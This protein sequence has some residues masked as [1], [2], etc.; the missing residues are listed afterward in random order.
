MRY[1]E[2]L[3]HSSNNS[4]FFFSF[5]N[6]ISE[7]KFI[8]L[9]IAYL[10]KAITTLWLHIRELRFTKDYNTILTYSF[11]KPLQNTVNPHF[12]SLHLFAYYRSPF[13]LSTE[14][15]IYAANP[16]PHNHSKVDS[17]MIPAKIL[18]ILYCYCHISTPIGLTCNNAFLNHDFRIELF[19]V[20]L[21]RK[22]V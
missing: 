3:F 1:P 17:I 22:Q 13:I 6:L 2:S 21:F 8:F 9:V 12:S 7:R 14:Y 4:L 15:A 20:L 10:E 16:F 11:D 19:F 5:C 18:S